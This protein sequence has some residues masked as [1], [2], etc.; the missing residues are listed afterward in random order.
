MHISVYPIF[1]YKSYSIATLKHSEPLLLE[2]YI[3]I[4]ALTPNLQKVSVY[5]STEFLHHSSTTEL[6]LLL[7]LIKGSYLSFKA[8]LLC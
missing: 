3:Y 8:S 1:L 2:N 5:R 7:I 6:L 4:V